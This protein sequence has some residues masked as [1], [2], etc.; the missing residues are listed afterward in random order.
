MDLE[1]IRQE[2]GNAVERARLIRRRADEINENEI[3]KWADEIYFG[4][5]GLISGQRIGR[6]RLTL[7]ST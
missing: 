6:V 5:S 2:I 1:V 7:N 3:S 4:L